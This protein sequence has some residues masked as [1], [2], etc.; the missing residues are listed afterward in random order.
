MKKTLLLNYGLLIILTVT[1]AF[2]S[3]YT[4]ITNVA[5]NLI[6]VASAFKFIIVA[7]QFMELKKANAF[8]KVSVIIVLFLI[9]TPILLLI[10]NS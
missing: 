1:T 8:W 7:F 4:S 3:N 10:N 9:I 5:V 2:L 6:L